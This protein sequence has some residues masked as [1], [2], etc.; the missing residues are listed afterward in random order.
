MSSRPLTREEYDAL[1]EV[2]TAEEV[3]AIL[4]TTGVQVRLWAA[5]GTLPGVQISRLW[6]FSK[7]RLERFIEDNGHT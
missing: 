4:G 2:L 7:S 3:A 6:R 5:D 1:P